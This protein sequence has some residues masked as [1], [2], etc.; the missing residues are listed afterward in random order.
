M[1]SVSSIGVLD[2]SVAILDA[3]VAGPAS[4]AALVDRTGLTR[5]TAHRLATGLENH[6]L[7]RR[8]TEGRFTLGLRLVALG[9]AATD[10]YPLAD[11]ARPALLRLR[12]A[13]GES[14][15][16]YVPDGGERLCVVSVD[17]IHELRTIVPTGSR[18]PIG[19]GS[20][21]RVLAGETGRHGWVSSVGERAPGVASVSAPIHNAAGEVIAAVS[22]SGPI[23]RT[24]RR[25]GPK[26]GPDVVAAAAEVEATRP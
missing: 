21:G 4:L 17:S 11:A 24:T 22:V 6:G 7:V 19:F 15:Q 2:K 26:F 20:A 1:D 25:P 9:R 13:S 3:L 10:A 14:A 18:L 5:A 8:D 12:D 16:L 23:D